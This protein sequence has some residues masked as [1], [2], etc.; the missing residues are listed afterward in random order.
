MQQ[1]ATM[2]WAVVGYK[3]QNSKLAQM[4]I[5]SEIKVTAGLLASWE[6]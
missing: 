2:I 4:I 3:T 1:K 5:G 6:L